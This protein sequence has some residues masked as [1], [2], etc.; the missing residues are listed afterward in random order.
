MIPFAIGLLV[1][2]G[3]GR[4]RGGARIAP[5]LALGVG[6]LVVGQIWWA[7]ARVDGY[8]LRVLG[9]RFS[10]EDG[11]GREIS[12]DPDRGDIYVAGTGHES[13]AV[14]TSRGDTLALERGPGRGALVLARSPATG[15]GWRVLGSV[16]LQDGDRVAL[17]DPDVV[18]WTFRTSGTTWAGDVHRWVDE[19]G[20]EAVV[21][22][23][24]GAG[25]MGLFPSRPDAFQ[26]S[27]PLADIP[28]GLS[29]PGEEARGLRSFLYYEDGSPRIAL[30]DDNLTVI[31][32]SGEARERSGMSLGV[33]DGPKARLLVAGLP[34]RDIEEPRL[35]AGERYGIRPLRSFEPRVDGDWVTLAEARQRV[36]AVGPEDLEDEAGLWLLPGQGLPQ[37][38]A[39]QITDYSNRFATV[40]QG[41]LRLP[42]DPPDDG[43]RILTPSGLADGMLGRPFTLG[44]RTRGLLFRVDGLHASLPFLLLLLALF[45]IGALAFPVLRLSAG[46]AGLALAA[47]GLVGL[48]ALMSFSAWARFPFVDEGHHLSLWLIPAV[49]WL[50]GGISRAFGRDTAGGSVAVVPRGFSGG[51]M[52]APDDRVRR[53]STRGEVPRLVAGSV[54]AA[55][56][57]VLARV[58]FPDSGAKAGVLA[59]MTLLVAVGVAWSGSRSARR[60]WATVSTRTRS[61]RDRWLGVAFPGLVGGLGLA[62]LRLLFDAVGFREQVTVGGTRIG[63][64]VFYTPVVVLV[65]AATLWA[66]LERAGRLEGK[67]DGARNVALAWID[68]GGLLVLSLALVSA[69]IS[70]FGIVLTILPGLAALMAAVG[71]HWSRR[72]GPGAALGGVLP[73]FLF[74]LLQASPESVRITGLQS[75]LE[76]TPTRLEEWSRNELLLLERGDPELLAL[77]GESRSEALAVMRET[78][79]SYTRGNW[80]GKGFLQGR[81][82]T[83]IR[84]TAAREHAAG[85]LVASQWGMVGSLGLVTLLMAMLLPFVGGGASRRARPRRGGGTRW[86]MLPV[87]LLTGLVGVALPSPADTVWLLAWTAAAAALAW[88]PLL[89]AREWRAAQEGMVEGGVGGRGTVSVTSRGGGRRRG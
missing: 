71:L 50:V 70:D 57:V 8:Q 79:R 33:G 28:L 58:L 39:L 81:V 17:A 5:W 16:P 26:R 1:L 11:A 30:L 4:L 73:L 15:E 24:D 43:F 13:L 88:A 68:L 60:S 37:P 62:G 7:G 56:L 72:F 32:A 51:F 54:V 12:G 64:S 74:G 89:P 67:S 6:L 59:A 3:I 80:F 76:G 31:P 63:I 29:G 46:G 36:E 10:V 86:G 40:S 66:H 21:P 35:E 9:Q 19:Q 22:Y 20:R 23:P 47:L 53:V 52:G 55:L 27:Y 69:W 25:T 34:L 65:F 84:A 87:L 41:L 14:L 61:L 18:L 38:G 48:R 75:S 44:D 77:I 45:G 83:E 2:L 42:S 85:A 49:P 82:S 78:M